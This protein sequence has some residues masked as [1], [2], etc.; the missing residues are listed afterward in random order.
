MAKI[1]ILTIHGMGRQKPNFDDELRQNLT[2]R[3]DSSTRD[4][5]IFK[6]I[7]YQGLIQGNQDKVWEAVNLK[8]G[9][10]PMPWR[11]L[12]GFAREFFLF[13]IGDA[14]SYQDRPS[15]DNSAYQAIHNK[16]LT[17]IKDLQAELDDESVPVVIIGR[18][19]GCHLISNYIYDA[20]QNEGLW[21]ETNKPSNFQSLGTTAFFFSAGCNI[22]LFV[23]GLNN[24]VPIQKPNPNF[25]WLNYYDKDGILGSPLQPL[26]PSYC[27]L[28]TDVEIR[29]S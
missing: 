13:S 9:W 23:A 21:S 28:A 1:G 24:I 20:Q 27:E 3:L 19:L 4:D 26:S 14:A 7:F 6:K 2:N 29:A 5:V 10:F 12:W 18:S 17:A 11:K 16:V 8:G 25:R 15:E 22:P